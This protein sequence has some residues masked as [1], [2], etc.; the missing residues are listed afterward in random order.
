MCYSN[1]PN[2]NYHGDCVKPSKAGLFGTHC[3]N[4]FQC[5][6]CQEVFP[7]SEMSETENVCIDCEEHYLFDKEND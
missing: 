1:C 6:H 5:K 7:E 2:E 3:C 4:D